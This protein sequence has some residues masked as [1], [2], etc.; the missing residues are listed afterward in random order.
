MYVVEAVQT[1]ICCRNCIKYLL[2]NVKINH[3]LFNFKNYLLHNKIKNQGWWHLVI[4]EVCQ[5]QVIC[6]YQQAVA[7]P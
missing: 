4:L 7:Y 5:E 2:E 1:K 3:K 6:T